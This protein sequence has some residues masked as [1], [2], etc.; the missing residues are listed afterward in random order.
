MVGLEEKI[1]PHARALTDEDDSGGKNYHLSR[2][3]FAF[4]IIF[5]KNVLFA[6]ICLTEQGR[7]PICRMKADRNTMYVRESGTCFAFPGG[8]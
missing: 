6:D 4:M 2:M 5:A 1:F 3:S 7:F 8:L